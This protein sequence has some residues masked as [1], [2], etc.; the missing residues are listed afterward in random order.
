MRTMKRKSKHSLGMT[1]I[2][3]L[4]ATLLASLM[5]GS[6]VGFFG[7]LTRQ[8]RVLRKRAKMPP[9]WHLQLA[10][11]LQWDLTNSREF[12]VSPDGV[13]LVGF[14]SRDFATDEP[15]GRPA[16]IA[17]YLIDAID[18]RWLAPA[19]ITATR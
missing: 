6:V 3:V 14:A 18:G 10:D 13:T 12:V 1:A 5:L 9:P 17:Y 7:A 15:T 4:V 8:E 11:Q 16:Q 19:S 2:E